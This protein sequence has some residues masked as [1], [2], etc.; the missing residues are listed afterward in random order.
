LREILL[1]AACYFCTENNPKPDVVVA[2]A[3]IV[4]G[5]PQPCVGAIVAV[6]TPNEPRVAGVHEVRV[7]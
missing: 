3:R 6:A 2:I 5:V 1:S 4:V 7:V